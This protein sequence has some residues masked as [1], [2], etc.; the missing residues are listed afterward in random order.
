M[1]EPHSLSDLLVVQVVPPDEEAASVTLS[2]D[3]DTVVAFCFPCELVAGARVPNLLTPL[4]TDFLRSAFLADWPAD[5]RA[6]AS[7]ERLERV[8]H[9]SYQGT[10]RVIDE[11]LG[12]VRVRGFLIDFGEVPA[13]ASH[14]EFKVPRFDVA[15]RLSERES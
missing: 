7:S 6:D 11:A 9:F 10:G 5:E 2:S 4:D 13:G 3:S 14:V 12:L 1:S 15:P 8:G